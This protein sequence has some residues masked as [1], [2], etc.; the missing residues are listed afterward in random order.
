LYA[1]RV[2]ILDSILYSKDD[3]YRQMYVN[4]P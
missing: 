3:H 1:T 4:L 2:N